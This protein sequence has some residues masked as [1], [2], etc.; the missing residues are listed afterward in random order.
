MGHRISTAGD[1]GD[2]G[3]RAAGHASQESSATRTGFVSH[4][5]TLVTEREPLGL[6]SATGSGPGVASGREARPLYTRTASRDPRESLRVKILRG[7]DQWLREE[8]E[9]RSMAASVEDTHE[10]SASQK[11]IAGVLA[12]LPS[13]DVD[14]LE[15]GCGR[16][17][18][19]LSL[20]PHVR[21]AIGVDAE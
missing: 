17:A 13:G 7:L 1:H 18:R 4:S 19:T 3:Q 21:S 5:R 20:A 11:S 15:F 14:V 10:A 8:S 6:R 9:A 2:G 16:G 12:E